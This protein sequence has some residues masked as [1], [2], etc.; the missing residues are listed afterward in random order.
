MSSLTDEIRED[1]ANGGALA[2]A[3]AEG[4]DTLRKNDLNHAALIVEAFAQDCL[5]PRPDLI[6]LA[7]RLRMMR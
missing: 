7:R 6:E 3:T 4:L 1:I 5:N 2:R